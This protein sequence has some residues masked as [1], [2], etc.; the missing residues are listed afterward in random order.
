MI[1]RIAAALMALMM[2]IA[3]T[4]CGSK[5]PDATGKYMCV[6]AIYSDGLGEPAGEWIELKNGG[7]GTYHDGDMDFEFEWKLSGETFNGKVLLWGLEN[8]MDGTL[9]DGVITVKYGDVDMRFEKDGANAPAANGAPVS[10]GEPTSNSGAFV[11]SGFFDGVNVALTMDDAFAG[12]VAGGA[13]GEDG[14]FVSPT[15]SIEL[16]KMWFGVMQVTNFSGK[17]D[18]DYEKDIIA[19]INET[20]AGRAFIEIYTDSS[21]SDDSIVLSMYIDTYTDSFVPNIGDKDAWVLERY[22]TED[23]AAYFAPVLEN[24]ALD[25]SYDYIDPDGKF[26]CTVRFF[27][28]EDGTPFDE[29]NDPLPPSYEDYKAAIV[30]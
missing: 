25:M 6:S 23:D 2:I 30:D 18:G 4:A 13:G 21:M 9:K 16:G 17:G 5:G 14:G 19:L 12:A 3:L 27:I 26:T 15:T 28:R 22:L 29:E 7:K 10:D 8:P 20:S 11:P 1:K 24:G